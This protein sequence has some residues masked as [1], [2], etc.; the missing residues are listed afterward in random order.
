MTQN[1]GRTIYIDGQWRPADGGATVAVTDP[2][3][4]EVI[5]QAADGGRADT[6]AAIAAADR[7]L[8]AWSGVTAYERAAVLA[9]ADALMRERRKELAALMT[10]EQGKPLKASMNEVAYAADF[11]AWFAEEA[12]RIGGV[13]IPSARADQRFVTMRQPISGS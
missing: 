7:A 11:L 4:G 10:R 8:P 13:T 6:E 1:P 3:T 12:K 9:K 2:A 5:G